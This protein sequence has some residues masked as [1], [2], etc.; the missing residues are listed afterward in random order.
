MGIRHDYFELNLARN[1]HA[2]LHAYVSAQMGGESIP[3]Y[4]PVLALITVIATTPHE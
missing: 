1:V 4:F 3:S 2:V